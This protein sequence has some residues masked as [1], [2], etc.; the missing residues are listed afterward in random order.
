MN[1]KLV[2]DPSSRTVTGTVKWGDGQIIDLGTR[3]S[4]KF[5]EALSEAQ[6]IK[7]GLLPPAVRWISGD[8]RI[9]VFERP[10][11]YQRVAFYQMEREQ[12][13]SLSKP[14]ATTEAPNY[15]RQFVLPMPWIVYVIGLGT[16]CQ[17]VTVRA[18]ARP[19][20]LTSGNDPVFLLPMLNFYT[21]SKLCQPIFEKFEAFVP[22]VAEGIQQAYN[23][24]WNSG[25]NYDLHDA[26]KSGSYSGYPVKVS[27]QYIKDSDNYMNYFA[28]W[29][30]ATVQ[31]VLDS[32]NLLNP[33]T[34]GDSEAV[35]PGTQQLSLQKAVGIVIKELYSTHMGSTNIAKNFMTN[36]VNN[37]N[38]C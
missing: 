16:G 11:A 24:V 26:V 12:A 33:S 20:P 29:E 22:T 14:G 1:L 9:V 2:E 7:V 6:N 19:G 21:N 4:D 23:M 13:A 3:D 25:F 27:K 18:Y 35:D 37:F 30:A 32:P 38:V 28:S 8:K 36:L 5:V 10:P 15:L 17:P 31:Q 34:K